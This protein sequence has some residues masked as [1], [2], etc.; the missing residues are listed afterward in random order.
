VPDAR[1]AIAVTSTR[2]TALL[3]TAGGTLV[4]RGG[5]G[6]WATVTT[7][8]KLAPDASLT[9]DSITWGSRG[10]GWLTGHGV[11]GAAVAFRT[12]DDGRTWSPM[13]GTIGS[14]V[15]ALAPCGTG[16]HWLLPFITGDGRMVV[17]RTSNGGH[18]WSAGSPLPLAAG[19]PAWG[20]HGDLVWATARAADADYLFTSSDAGGHWTQRSAVPAGLSDLTP[21]A[22]G[23]GFATSRTSAG[24]TL[25]A[26]SENGERFTARPLPAW[27]ATAGAQMSQS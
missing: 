25:W 4:S 27:V 26:V 24:S 13:S 9:L 23:S 10:L 1:Q 12:T 15:A 8:G 19:S 6:S 17:A 21:V 22:A 20:C 18:T 2:T 16:Q 3:R 14:A 11:A 7:A 5:A